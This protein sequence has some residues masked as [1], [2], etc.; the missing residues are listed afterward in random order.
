[1]QLQWKNDNS[2]C[3]GFLP[4]DP[5]T[6]LFRI[7]EDLVLSG[8]IIPDAERLSKWP[9]WS[10]ATQA[11]QQYLDAWLKRHALSARVLDV[12][13]HLGCGFASRLADLCIIAQCNETWTVADSVVAAG[14]EHFERISLI[15]AYECWREALRPRLHEPADE[16]AA[17]RRVWEAAVQ[18]LAARI[19]DRAAAESETGED[20][21]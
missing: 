13:D 16:L 2:G 6:T 3:S 19:R 1:M 7:S 17:R 20:R 8:A 11:A 9:S 18:R 21:P 5:W 12:R 14:L 4:G 15:H 10:A